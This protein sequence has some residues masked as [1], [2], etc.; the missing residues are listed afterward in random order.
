MKFVA[1]SMHTICLHPGSLSPFCVH[2]LPTQSVSHYRLC[3]DGKPL[4]TNAIYVCVKPWQQCDGARQFYAHS[5][6]V[7]LA[8]RRVAHAHWTLVNHFPKWANIIDSTAKF[9]SFYWY[10]LFKRKHY[11]S[12]CWFIT[13]CA[14]HICHIRSHSR[15]SACDFI[16]LRVFFLSSPVVRCCCYSCYF[17][18]VN[19][20][21]CCAAAAAFAFAFAAAAAVYFRH[22]C[23]S[24][25]L[26]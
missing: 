20:I 8:N 23:R 24:P 3:S 25:L 9:N 7:Y 10:C 22:R 14:F 21:H 6:C 19:F 11:C 5:K 15:L 18:F 16:S 17:H 12:V 13:M 2:S 4:F 1:L 26:I